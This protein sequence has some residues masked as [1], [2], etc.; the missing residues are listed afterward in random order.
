MHSSYVK[1]VTTAARGSCKSL[2]Q[3]KKQQKSLLT[4]HFLTR[5]SKDS[6]SV[7]QKSYFKNLSVTMS[8]P[9]PSTVLVDELLSSHPLMRVK[10]KPRVENLLNTLIEG[11]F[12]KL[13]FVIDFD[14]TLTKT[15]NERGESLDCSWGVMENSPLLSEE[16]TKECNAIR[17][18]YLPI[19]LDPKMSIEEKIPHMVA[20]YT[21][22]N[23]ALQKSGVHKKD[24][25]DMVKA[26]NVEFRDGSND[27]LNFLLKAEIPVLVLSAGL[28]DLIVA[29][30]QNKG[31]YHP[32][33]KVVSNFLAYDDDD[34]VVGLDGDIIHVY[35][36]NESA[37][38]DSDYFKILQVAYLLKNILHIV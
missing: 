36:K 13:Q 8:S 18:H 33:L 9:G 28:G 19:E 3:P 1:L 7:T 23:K 11:G 12:E 30:L 37:I 35:N 27:M 20:W 32:N 24:F 4:K 25:S 6:F 38:H 5:T 15:K 14:H 31:A 29:I 2:G 22:A 16:Y 10:D 17:A 21:E 34:R 26:S